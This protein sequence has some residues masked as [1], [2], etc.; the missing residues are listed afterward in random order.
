MIIDKLIRES[1]KEDSKLKTGLYGSKIIHLHRV[2]TEI[3]KV[4]V[5]SNDFENIKL[6]DYISTTI[7]E[8]DKKLQS[9]DYGKNENS[10]IPSYNILAKFL[11]ISGDK[12]SEDALIDS[13]IYNRTLSYAINN[14]KIS[15]WP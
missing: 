12:I 7:H 13:S 4:E 15:K 1:L 11:F 5:I 3:E 8:N 10:M 2:N 6:P 9:Y 14:R